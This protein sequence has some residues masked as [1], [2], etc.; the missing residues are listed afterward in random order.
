MR[1]LAVVPG[2]YNTSPGQRYRIEQ[3]EP[4]LRQRGVEINYASFENAELNLVMYQRGHLGRKLMLVSQGM[5]GRVSL[6]RSLHEYDVVYLFREAALLGPSLFERWI[7]RSGVPMVFDFDDA[8]FVTYKSPSNGYLSYLKFA[9]KART[10]CRI[11]SHVM[12]GNPYLAD[13][14]RQFNDRVTIVPSTIDTDKYVMHES[15]LPGPLVIGW[16]GS[17]STVQHLDTIRPALQRLAKNEQFSLRVIG[18]TSYELPGV[19]VEARRWQADTEVEDLDG[20]QIGLMPLPNDKWSKGKCGMKALQFMGLGIPTVCSPVGVNTDIIQDGQNGFIASC[21][22]EWVEKLT[23]L[24]RSRD[25][26]RKLGTAARATVE[27]K[28]SAKTHAPRVYEILKSVVR[29]AG[30]AQPIGSRN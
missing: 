11:A 29:A 12:V 2:L 14:A 17:H 10:I 19:Q 5:R 24:L 21:E 22:D 18:T 4:L 9:G 6:M 3:W 23:L 28:Y 30:N 26:R 13:F 7:H 1:V 16:T 8:I 27:E 20:I 25:L 15:N